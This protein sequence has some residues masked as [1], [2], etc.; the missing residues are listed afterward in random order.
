MV[1]VRVL[2]F[3]VAALVAMP[4]G[5]CL[6][7]QGSGFA[8]QEHLEKK[9]I[10][11][12]YNGRLLTA[13]CYYDSIMKPVLYPVK[14]LSGVA[15]TRGYPLDPR[16][17]E[18]VD[19]P[20][21]V[22]LWLN[23]QYVN[24]LDFWNNS[25]AISYG[26]RNRYGTIYHDEIVRKEASGQKAL[27]EV[28]ALWKDHSD[29]VLLTETTTY[30]F[31]VS[32]DD[33]IVD[34][35][36]TLQASGGDVSLRDI[37]DGFLAIRVARELE[38]PSDESAEVVGPGGEVIE[39][40]L[41]DGASGDYLS[42]EGLTGNDVWGTRARWVTLTGRKDEK[43]VSITIIDHPGNP[44][45]PAYWHARGYGLFAV[46]PLGQAAFSD[47][48]ERLNLEVKE[49]DAVTFRYRIVVHEGPQLTPDQVDAMAEF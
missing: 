7:A 42:S 20:H 46:N 45:Y 33:F 21:H 26:S 41:T 43:N 13:Y 16:A 10:D 5:Q 12:T 39:I 28:R 47:G 31:S 1:S 29:A 36:T 34:R 23:Y 17:G 11:V 2:R 9:Q 49:N 37:K 22:G 32:G 25:T 8:F 48:K 30:R 6:L 38:L 14:T 24:G 15:V 44:G 40:R 3:I 27:L 4:G 35:T 19:H 18:R